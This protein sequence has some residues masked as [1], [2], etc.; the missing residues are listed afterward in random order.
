MSYWTL[1][2]NLGKKIEW[3]DY[4]PYIFKKANFFFLWILF[5]SLL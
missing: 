5:I 2:R 3:A 1:L 4:F